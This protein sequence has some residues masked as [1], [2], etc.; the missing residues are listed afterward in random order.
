MTQYSEFLADRA[1]GCST[2]GYR[3][4]A[5][6]LVNFASPALAELFDYLRFKTYSTFC[7]YKFVI[8]LITYN[9][10]MIVNG[11]LSDV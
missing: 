7:T 4:L 6:L 10:I 2:I 8:G 9:V 1:S 11:C 3:R 5:E